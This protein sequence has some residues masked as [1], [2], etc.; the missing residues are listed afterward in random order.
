MTT[1]AEKLNRL[2]ESYANDE[3]YALAGTIAEFTDSIRDQHSNPADFA[4]VENSIDSIAEELEKMADNLDGKLTKAE[5]ADLLRSIANHLL[6]VKTE[7]PDPD[8]FT[9]DFGALES[10][11]A[12]AE[13]LLIYFENE[14]R[15]L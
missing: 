1:P 10:A 8:D 4:D 13:S 5:A 11:H 9:I 12:A 14:A 15:A 3:R 2:C 7:L 6:D